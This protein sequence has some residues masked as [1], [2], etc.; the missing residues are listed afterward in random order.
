[1]SEAEHSHSIDKLVKY[2]KE[3]AVF[4]IHE[5]NL[6]LKAN[7]IYLMGEESAAL[8]EDEPG[9]EFSMANRFIRNLNIMMRLSDDP[10]LIHMKTCGGDWSEGMA[11]YDAIC[12]CP[13]PVAILSYTHA[14]SMSSIIFC[15]A[16]RRIMMPHSTFMIHQGESFYGGTYKQAQTSAKMDE[17]YNEQMLKVYVDTLRSSGTMKKWSRKRIKEYLEEQMNKKEEVYWSA[18]QAVKVGFADAVFG[19]DG[20]WDWNTLL[21]FA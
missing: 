12:A 11:I 10:I 13:N 20:T 1:M 7:H 21:D 15:A 4:Q 6:D 8:D 2:S 3:D 16:D 19:A 18:E 17:V 9:V 14:R 5:Y